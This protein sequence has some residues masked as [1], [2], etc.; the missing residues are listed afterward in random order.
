MPSSSPKSSKD[1]VH[2]SKSWQLLKLW[3][4]LPK[5]TWIERKLRLKRHE[6]PLVANDSPEVI[7]T[8]WWDEDGYHEHRILHPE[9]GAR[10]N[11]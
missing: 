2:L 11:G 8:V 7:V 6:K 9:G 10:L 5:L 4:S 3:A 1:S